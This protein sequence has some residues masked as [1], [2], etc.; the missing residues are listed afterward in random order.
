MNVDLNLKL[1]GDLQ[2]YDLPYL[3]LYTDKTTSLFYLAFRI[4]TQRG[5]VADYVVAPVSSN[6]LLQYLKGEISVRSLFHT[7]DVLYLWHRQRGVKG[8]ISLS[9][10]RNLESCIENS[11]YNP[12]LCDDEELIMDYIQGI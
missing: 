5:P 4:T 6:Y 2:V 10:D 9:N 7:S 12:Q 8:G 3:S 1:L 11:M